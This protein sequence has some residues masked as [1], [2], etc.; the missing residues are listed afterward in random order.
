MD[1]LLVREKIVG[2]LLVDRWVTKII[3]TV[4]IMNKEIILNDFQQHKGNTA[5]KQ[6]R[7]HGLNVDLQSHPIEIN[8]LKYCG[9]V[10]LGFKCFQLLF[11]SCVKFT[12]MF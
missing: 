11:K 10:R 6:I 3:E 1:P 4:F 2:G 9:M 8:T 12:S 5:P 7:N